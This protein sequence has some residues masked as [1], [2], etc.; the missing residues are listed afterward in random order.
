MKTELTV[1]STDGKAEG[2]VKLPHVFETPYRPDVIRRAYINL[3][4]HM[5]QEQG[6]YPAAGELV[7]A[8]SRNTGL[9]I[10]RLARIRGQGF[11]RAGQAAGVAGVRA[12]RI[13]HPPESWKD[14]YKKINKKE[15][16]LAL[17]SAIAATS[18]KDIIVS[19]GHRVEGI[20]DFPIIAS[21]SIESITKSRDLVQ[22]LLAFGLAEDLSRSGASKVKGTKNGSRAKST[23][24]GALVVVRKGSNVC[25][26]GTSIPG[27]DVKDVESLSVLDL[28]PGAK[29]IRLTVFSQGSLEHL[30]K[31]GRKDH[32]LVMK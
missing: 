3:L 12:G 29:P 17:S 6:R 28:A 31:Y 10:A 4:S 24:T 21:D 30:E 19:R 32:L 13:A 1:M 18:H 15:R 2:T 16:Q 11:S 26:L 22:T 20:S 9:G 23:G 14:I 7:S 5:F 27:I 25:R 8:E